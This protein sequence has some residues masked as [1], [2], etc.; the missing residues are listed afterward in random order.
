MK[1]TSEHRLRLLR[2]SAT[3]AG[4]AAFATSMSMVQANPPIATLGLPVGVDAIDSTSAGA[5]DWNTDKINHAKT[6]HSEQTAWPSAQTST[7][8]AVKINQFALKANRPPVPPRLG[9]SVAI[10]QQQAF[11]ISGTVAIA[12]PPSSSS[13]Q[14]HADGLVQPDEVPADKPNVPYS[15]TA[16][17]NVAIAPPLQQPISTPSVWVHHPL[18]ESVARNPETQVPSQGRISSDERPTTPIRLAASRHRASQ[19]A[20]VNYSTS[21]SAPVLPGYSLDGLRQN[22]TELIHSASARLD[23]HAYLTATAQ[24][25]DALKLIAQAI[26]ARQGAAVA[27]SDLTQA[28]TAI[29]EAEDFVG[30]YGMVD[31]IAIK[32]MVRSHATE[33]LKPY[34][35]TN[36]SGLAAADV[37]LDWSRRCLT[38]LA[39]ADPIASEALY[40]MAEAYRLRDGGTPFGLATSVH[41]MRAASEGQPQNGVIAA[42]IQPVRGNPVGVPTATA[43]EKNRLKEVQL[44]Q[45]SPQQFA[46]LS[47]HTAGPVGPPQPYSGAI[48]THSPPPVAPAKHTTSPTQNKPSPTHTASQ[49]GSDSPETSGSSRFSRAIDPLRRLWH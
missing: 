8:S 27:S 10:P 11:R 5:S 22:A 41:L 15:V 18:E 24:A 7:K 2:R 32:R 45:V 44:L 12:A 20:S 25:T 16:S 9:S 46:A 19:P 34:D 6:V 40:V 39:S 49:A 37:Y 13:S 48:Q 47:P 4:V 43:S 31:S 26:D 35:T 28:L 3:L 17:R 38:Q 36:L 21:E 33:V 1:P 14:K 23:T 29:R 30:K 42:A